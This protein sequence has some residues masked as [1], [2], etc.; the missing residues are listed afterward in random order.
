MTKNQLEPIS[1]AEAKEMYLEARKHEV[2]QSTLDGY[3]YRLVHFTRWCEKQGIGN[4][5]DLSGRDLQ[6]FKTW[7]RDDGE[8]KSITLEGNLDALRTFLRWCESIDAVEDGLHD[9][10]IMPVLKKD[11]EQSD[12][13]L[14]MG[15]AK[16][17]LDYLRQFEYASRRH[18][19]LEILWHTGIRLGTLRSLDLDDYDGDNERLTIRHR[20]ETETPLKNGKQGER[21]IALDANICRVIEAY[22]DYHRRD[23]ED[24]HGREPLLRT[25]NGRMV[26]SSIRD[27]MYRITR[28]CYY[29]KDCSHDRDP[30]T[31]EAAGYGGWSKCPS[32]VPPHPIRRSSITHFL[33]EDMPEK[34]VNDRMNVGRDVLDKH[35]DKRDEEVKVE[36]RRGYLDNI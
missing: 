25:R 6:Q 1:P 23:V 18:T 28:P 17:I 5:N 12:Q 32:S 8:L 16:E 21:M 29:G 11:D 31:C 9:K 3:H 35:Y 33:T 7:R 26:R 30:D 34:V 4:M 20:P 14:R 19:I 2:S 13:I 10:I 22:I 15:R 27:E 24:S 36:Q